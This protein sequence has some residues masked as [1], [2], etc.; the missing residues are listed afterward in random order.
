MILIVVGEVDNR[1][2]EHGGAEETD[3]DAGEKEHRRKID[4]RR[5]ECA[6]IGFGDGHR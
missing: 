4:R 6:S 2:Q 3:D 5:L 1:R